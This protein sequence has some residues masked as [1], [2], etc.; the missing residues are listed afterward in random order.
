MEECRNCITILLPHYDIKPRTGTP[1]SES[2]L[3]LELQILLSLLVVVLW[4][5][6]QWWWWQWQW[7]FLRLFL[8][9]PLDRSQCLLLLQQWLSHPHQLV[10]QNN[11]T[12]QSL[13]FHPFHQPFSAYMLLRCHTPN[14]HGTVTISS[15]HM[16]QSITNCV[17]IF[18]RR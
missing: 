16:M 7:Q 15:N 3:L 13:K 17:Q 2:S 8:L 6:L 12:L 9:R 10:S 1:N 14:N 11:P 5:S 4:L 18:Y